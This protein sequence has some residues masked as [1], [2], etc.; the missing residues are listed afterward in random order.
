MLHVSQTG[1]VRVGLHQHVV[2]VC[3][4]IATA[5]VFWFYNGVHI[6]ESQNPNLDMKESELV[7]TDPLKCIRQRNLTVFTT[8]EADKIQLDCRAVALYSSTVAMSVPI[9]I[10]V[11]GN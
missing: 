2:F 9:N 6:S 10:A 8:P 3:E 4:A 1:S 7:P 5:G 11:E